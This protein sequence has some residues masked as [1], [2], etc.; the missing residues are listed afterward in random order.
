LARP[1]GQEVDVLSS[2]D[3]SDE[4]PDDRMR[5]MFGPGQIDQVVRQAIQFCWM[6]LP[7]EKRNVEEVERQIRRIVDRALRDLR[8]D[9][10]NFFGKKPGSGSA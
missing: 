3:M 7:K 6:G 2:I 8:E 4:G 9:F 10:D 1:V 5:D